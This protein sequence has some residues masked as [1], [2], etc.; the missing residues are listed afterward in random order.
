MAFNKNTVAV[1]CKSNLRTYFSIP[2]GYVFITLFIFLSAAAAFWQERFFANNLANLDQLNDFFPLLLILFVPAVTMGVWAD[3]RRQGTDELLLTLPAS[4]LEVVL[5][6]YLSVVGI[7]T[8]SLLLSLS[9][10]LVLFWLGSPDIGLMFANYLG[11][12]LIGLALLA[13]G[14]LASLFTANATIGFVLGAVFC[15]ALVLVDSPRWVVSESLQS[16]L[17]PLGVHS[18]FSDFA[19]GVVSLKGLLY[20]SSVVTVALYLNVIIIGRR[21]WP[22]SAGGYRYWVHQVVRALAVVVA[23]IAITVIIGRGGFRLDTTGEQLH[24]LSDE[25]EQLLDE[26]PDDRPVLIQAFM[27][28]E[29]PRAYVETRANLLGKLS[30][31]SAIAG[32]RIQLLIHDTEPFTDEARDAREKFNI[33][34]R[35]VLV[36]ESARSSTSQVFMGVAFTSGAR[37]EVVPFFDRGLPV[38]YELIRSIRVVSKSHRK[39]VGVLETKVKLFGGF[40]YKTMASSPP[41]S[42]VAEL[43]RQYDVIQV[44]ADAPI[45]QEMDALVVALPSSL[46]QSQMDN[47]RAYVLQGSP[48]LLL[49]DPLPAIDPSMSPSVPAGAQM[50]PFMQN[51]APQEE[52]KGNIRNFMAEIGIGWGPSQ[53]VWDSYNPHPDLSS[54]PPEIIFLGDGNETAEIFSSTYRATSGLQELVAIYPGYLFKGAVDG[55][56]FQPLLRTGRASG[57]LNWQQVVQRSFFGL[58]INRNVRRVPSNESYIMAA[59]VF[60]FQGGVD[61]KAIDDRSQKKINAIVIADL[62]FISEQFFQIRSQAI[63]GYNFDNVTFFLN[64]I[65]MLVGDESFID[66]RKKRVKHRTL[67]TVEAQTAEYLEQR[68]SEEKEAEEKAQLAL[69]EAQRRLNEKVAEVQNRDDLDAQA[70]QIMARNL[71]EAE[72]RR[73][74]VLRANIEA[75]KEATIQRSK[76]NTETAIK[77]IQSRI[78]TLAVTLPPIPVF[79]LGV[80][81]FLRRRRRERDS[82]AAVRRLRS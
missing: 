54:L 66:L 78:R 63:A 58:S 67:E 79:T 74:E 20:F 33:L 57:M 9:H 39:T 49:I 46:T 60:G 40:D 22:L 11:Y 3:E 56:E 34:P 55:F 12:W 81:I 16:M 2:T 61:S 71:Q 70:K 38:E 35:E 8:A 36:T 62:D 59:R 4:D 48:T 72:N 31:I 18:Y 30:E 37:E 53:L 6:K 23:T 50:N 43:K 15:S 44:S 19:R 42:V 24:S 41:W 27:S 47:L 76:E 10:V 73:F 14:M 45:T 28:P 65:D 32:D 21:H 69:G 82:A 52:P 77:Q 25:T 75:R 64:S 26:L 17:A 68:L 13:V 29:V 5:G 7:Y 51:Q 80:V 1:I